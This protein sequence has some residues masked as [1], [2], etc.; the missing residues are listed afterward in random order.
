VVG[1]RDHKMLSSGE[2]VPTATTGPC[3]RRAM[4]V[5]LKGD[6]LARPAPAG[7]FSHLSRLPASRSSTI[8]GMSRR[9]QFSMKALLSLTVFIGVLLVVC[10]WAANISSVD[11]AIVLFVS[12]LFL[13]AP[14]C[15]G[16]R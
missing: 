13:W 12:S 16:K 2:L 8:A 5:G 1:Y 14:M 10:K 6:H 9:F 7:C 4:I 15:F 3:A 11:A